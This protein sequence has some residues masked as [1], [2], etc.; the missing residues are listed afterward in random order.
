MQPFTGVFAPLLSRMLNSTYRDA[1]AAYAAWRNTELGVARRCAAIRLSCEILLKL[2]EQAPS[3]ARLSTLARVGWE[4]G[5]RSV[6][7][8]ALRSL[9]SNAQRGLRIDE[10]F[11]PAC[12]RFDVIVPGNPWT[13]WFM[14]SAFEQYERSKNLSSFYG[15]SGIDLDWLCGSPYSS[16]EMQRRRV[17]QAWRSGRSVPVPVELGVASAENVNAALWRSGDLENSLGI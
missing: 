6:T 10:P 4:A 5:R 13:N 17:L 1:L 2:C 16:P 9:L 12:P 8:V 3:A 15:A 7:V 14:A 11:W